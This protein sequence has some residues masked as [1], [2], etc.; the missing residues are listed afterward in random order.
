MRHRCQEATNQTKPLTISCEWF[1]RGTTLSID[2]STCA[3]KPNSF[4]NKI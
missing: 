4:P 2:R 1:E 3:V